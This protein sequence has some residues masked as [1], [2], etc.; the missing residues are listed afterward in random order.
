MADTKTAATGEADHPVVAELEATHP[1][2]ADNAR[3]YASSITA[4]PAVDKTLSTDSDALSRKDEGEFGAEDKGTK[5]PEEIER[6][7]KYL[8]GTKLVLVFVGML[9]SILLVALDQ[10]IL[11]PAL[12]VIASKFQALDQ[13]AWIASAYFLTQT[14]FLLLYGQIL[15]LFDRKWTFL[16]AIL[17]FELGSLVC[18]VAKNVD[19]LI[20]GRAFAGCGAAGIFVSCLSI[21][22]EVTRLE[23]RPKLF[24]L[25]G[26]VFAL[27]SVIGPLMGGAF[28]DHVSWRWCFFINLPIGALTVVAIMFILGPQPPPPMTETVAS[29]TERK[30]KRWTFGLWTPPRTSLAFR[31]FALDYIGTVL[32]IATIACLVLALQWGGVKYAW[33]DGPVVATLVVFAILVPTVVLFEW[34]FA[35]PSRILPLGY[36][37]DRS[38]AGACMC[39]FFTM[40]VLLV[41]T[42]YLPTFYQATRFHSATKSGIDILPFMLGVTIAAGV[43][44]A[45]IS[46]FGY[47]WPFL[48]FGPIFSCIGSGL[49]YTV[50]EHTSSAKLIGF[51]IIL[52]IGVGAVLQNTIIAVQADCDDETEVPQK[53]ALVTFA[54]LVGGTIGIAIASSIFGTKLGSSLHEFAP[55]APFQLVRNSVEAIPTLPKAMQPGVIH[56]YTTALKDVFIIGA[57]AGGLT[58]L[59]AIPIRNLSVK[60]KNMAGGGA[61]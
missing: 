57:A 50:D 37:V 15:T 24:G 18:A 10:T 42:Y 14:A 31:L 20:F 25:F 39:A 51:Q 8:T 60:G 32:M 58:S 29:Y 40:F 35:G 54:Q 55:E 38:Q 26:A 47:Y 59:C 48:V 34:K 45:L 36:F 23:D 1:S 43:C 6:E 49:L 11:A 44:G 4:A 17:I 30:F 28:T 19:V 16:F 53:T 13:I 9:L 41:S 22:A 27:S 61:A 2:S 46:T 52:A 3:S 12:P 7:S 21:I 5:T 33:H 56:A